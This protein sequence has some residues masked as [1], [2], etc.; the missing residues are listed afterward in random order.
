MSAVR[1]LLV[2]LALFVMALSVTTEAEAALSDQGEPQTTMQVLQSCLADPKQPRC[3]SGALASIN[4]A[5]TEIARMPC[6]P[7]VVVGAVLQQV[8]ALGA[9]TSDEIS[10]DALQLVAVLVAIWLAVRIGRLAGSPVVTEEDILQ[11]RRDLWSTLGLLL[12]VAP[13]AADPGLS[14]HLYWNSLTVPIFA[15]AVEMSARITE[16][17]FAQLGTPLP[18]GCDNIGDDLGRVGA[19]L[20][21][22]G[23]EA[24]KVGISTG[25]FIFTESRWN[26]VQAAVGAAVA[27]IFFA[28]TVKMILAVVEAIVKLIVPATL[29]PLIVLMVIWRPSRSMAKR[30]VA[31]VVYA[32]MLI[33]ALAG[34][35]TAVVSVMQVTMLAAIILAPGWDHSGT[36]LA[37]EALLIIATAP[38]LGMAGITTIRD[39]VQ[40]YS[41]WIADGAPGG[42]A[43]LRTG[44]A[45]VAGMAAGAAGTAGRLAAKSRMLGG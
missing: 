25:S 28:Y 11:W 4:E 32:F 6:P 1:R 14:F 21:Q 3:S 45:K 18:T 8:S 9:R 20:I 22:P 12:L 7:C 29:S 44:V 33:V 27:V 15:A 37:P 34:L 38:I 26:L 17:L 24:A 43:A 40:Q 39:E 35:T 2:V 5:A 23:Y 36:G 13:V 41:A 19:C 30:A 10:G 16:P 31:A 42:G